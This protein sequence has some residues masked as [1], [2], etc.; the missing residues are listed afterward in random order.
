[1]KK[2]LFAVPPS[3]AKRSALEYP[4]IY[5]PLGILYLAAAVRARLGWDVFVLDGQRE[6]DFFRKVLRTAPD[7]IALSFH[8]FHSEDAKITAGKIR[9]LLPETVLIAGGNHPTYFPA[10]TARI[11]DYVVVGEGEETLPE[12]LEALEK[13]GR[14][15]EIRGLAFRKSGR[16]FFAGRR[17]FKR[18]I[19]ELPLPARDLVDCKSYP[20]FYYQKRKP[21]T[22]VISSRGCPYKCTF[23]SKTWGNFQRARSPGNF[24]DELELLS[25]S[26]VREIYDWAD[27]FN[28]V[29][30][31]SSQVLS[32]IRARRLDLTFKA[33]FR[34]NGLGRE[35]AEELAKTGFWLANV[36]IE[37]A[38]GRT[39]AGI[40]KG[41]TIPQV[42]SA[43]RNLKR[44]GLKTLGFFIGFNIWE[45]NG[46]LKFEGVRE[47]RLTLKLIEKL[48]KERLL[49]YFT[50]S[51]PTPYPGSGLYSTAKRHGLLAG[52]YSDATSH[53]M[54]VRLPG[55]S[56]A[57]IAAVKRE[58]TI[59]QAGAAFSA[60]RLN[61]G[62]WKFY[63]SK[64]GEQ[65]KPKFG[66][67]KN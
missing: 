15:S 60:G 34:A 25:Q 29:P 27:E 7:Y 46:L 64:L 32:E 52:N 41:V 36:G 37:S 42:R 49:D 21:D 55:I 11:F 4:P 63:L 40:R 35:Y 2:I 47:T 54:I 26:G 8:T 22:S 45:E 50:F 43:L 24:A 3:E 39:L 38:N 6:K 19:D 48:L 17:P 14:L 20:G 66:R 56:G 58:A 31:K 53:E 61:P 13:K 33:Q 62:I 67:R 65:L 10:E 23:C 30:K 44:A 57:E 5:P 9:A 51:L 16:F 1:M 59:L 18:K 28:L 12:L